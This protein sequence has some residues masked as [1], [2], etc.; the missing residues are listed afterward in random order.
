MKINYCKKG[1][2]YGTYFVRPIQNETRRAKLIR[3]LLNFWKSQLSRLKSKL[4]DYAHS[5][6]GKLVNKNKAN[7]GQ[8]SDERYHS[9]WPFGNQLQFLQPVTT[10]T[11]SKDNLTT[12][13]YFDV[14]EEEDK[15][16]VQSLPL[17][18]AKIKKHSIVTL[19]KMIAVKRFESVCEKYV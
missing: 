8:G 19:K 11:K 3:T 16:D 6:A 1:N 10:V 5:L 18:T 13:L 17:T 7:S 4:M 15:E 9:S 14:E 2:V 12:N